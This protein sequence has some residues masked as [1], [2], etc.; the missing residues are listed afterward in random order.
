MNNKALPDGVIPS[1]DWQDMIEPAQEESARVLCVKDF[2]YGG[3][4][5]AKGVKYNATLYRLYRDILCHVHVAGEGR[6][7]LVL[8]ISRFDE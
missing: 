2:I 8:P 3:T 5:L 6:K 4:A 7:A 1:D